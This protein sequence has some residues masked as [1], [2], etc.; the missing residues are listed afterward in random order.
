[1]ASFAILY[2]STHALIEVHTTLP[3]TSHS[4]FL[5]DEEKASPT[6]SHLSDEPWGGYLY[7]E[8]RLTRASSDAGYASRGS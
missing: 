8:L 3:R 6:A 5:E 2:S 7:M 1:M 4:P